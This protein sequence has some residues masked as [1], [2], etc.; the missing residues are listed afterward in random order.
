[1]YDYTELK[2]IFELS[3]KFVMKIGILN[4]ISEENICLLRKTKHFKHIQLV[5]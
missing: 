5:V 2:L 1:M 4:N 3:V